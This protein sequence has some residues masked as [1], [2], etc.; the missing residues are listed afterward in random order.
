M[1]NV[2]AALAEKCPQFERR[3][4]KTDAIVRAV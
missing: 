2:E 4:E 3:H 1:E